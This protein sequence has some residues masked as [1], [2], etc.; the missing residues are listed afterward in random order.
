AGQPLRSWDERGH[1]FSFSYDDP[2][3]RLTQKRV[4]GGDGPA[5]LD[6]VFERRLYGEGVAGDKAL[7][8]RGQVAVLYDTSGKTE[9]LSFDFK[10]HVAHS[11]R[12]FAADHRKVPDWSGP[13]PDALLDGET[14]ES[15]GVYDA[16][17]RV[18]E[19]STPDGSVYRPGYNE[20]NLLETV[21]VTQDG[22]TRLYVKNVDYDEK[23]RRQ[24]IVFGNDVSV[25]YA[26]D[27]ETF[28]LLNLSSRRPGGELL[29]DFHYTYDPIG[30]LTHLEDRCVPA[31]WFGNQMV[32]GLATYRYDPLYRLIEATGREHPGQLAAGAADNWD[33]APFLVR[34][35][36]ADPMVWR[37]YTEA[38]A[39]DEAGNLVKMQHAAAGG[40]WTRD[41]AYAAGNNRL[42]STQVGLTVFPYGHH[43]A[44]GYF[45]SMPHLSLMRWSF[46]DELKAVATQVV[47]AGT[48]ETTWY[49]YDG[50]GN[51]V[52]KVTD[53]EAAPD[54]DA[55]KKS[56]RFYLDGVEIYREYG[57][58]GATA[59]ERRTFHVMDDRQRV[60]M[61][62][63]Q[64]VAT[65]GPPDPA[66]VRYQGPDH[67]GSARLETDADARVISYEEYHPFGTTAYKAVDKDV[68]AAAR[69]YRYTEME[70][71]EE[72]GLEH[73]GARYYVPWLGRWTAPD[74]LADQLTGNRYAYV[75]NNPVIHFDSNGMFEEPLHGATTFRLLVAAGFT[76]ADAA[77]IALADAAMDH[78]PDDAADVGQT[79]ATPE[80]VRHGHFDPE[81]AVSRI[82][83]D[84]AGF[85]GRTATSPSD[86]AALET[87][88]RNLHNLEDVGFPDEPGPHMRGS[89]TMSRDLIVGG[90]WLGAVGGV[91]M[92][93][94]HASGVSKDAKSGLIGAA[95]V[96]FWA[97]LVLV[98][99]GFSVIGMGH[100]RY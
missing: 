69:R 4:T 83:A 11:A 79:I 32:T 96:L 24:R 55:A 82:E 57:A 58:G 97:S 15:S 21:Q 95:F 18:A 93:V 43:P 10:G 76:P 80:R 51:R 89:K 28:R 14:F 30:N 63:R 52:R 5:P 64:T 35:G 86:P 65:G 70:R 72:S 71:D 40:D 13:G 45:T 41:Y 73:H 49:V 87:F 77:R 67:L 66:L 19:R 36:A 2:L 38:Y 42:L 50:D 22:A 98:S 94:A 81:H 37:N 75:K 53:R 99:I 33:D 3:H 84:I 25:A 90:V 6:H 31:V 91:L 48:P 61:I 9:N 88:G 26:Y 23:G 7:N 16:L 27:K 1:V 47:N 56:E 60:A 59:T 46:R 68:I 62:D 29:Q 74:K 85:R 100:G 54:A 12:R 8:L 20:A 34:H 39:Y 78:D 92:G 44:H 17:D